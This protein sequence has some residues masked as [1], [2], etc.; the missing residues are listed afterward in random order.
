MTSQIPAQILQFR[1][2]DFDA[3]K[4]FSIDYTQHNAGYFVIVF[5]ADSV[6]GIRSNYNVNDQMVN[7]DINVGNLSALPSSTS[8]G[9]VSDG[10]Y[11]NQNQLLFDK[12]HE[13]SP[14]KILE[15]V[16]VHATDVQ[17]S[18]QAILIAASQPPPP[19]PTITVTPTTDETDKTIDGM[20]DRI[21]HDLD[22]LLNRM[23]EIPPAPP[24]P[25][26]T[27]PPPTLHST[28]RSV[29]EVILEE[30]AEDL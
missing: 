10:S 4:P 8:N 13:K 24:P 5:V 21:S 26:T 6:I 19:P 1:C 14:Q 2:S 20:L 11:V 22:Y 28:N 17:T 9:T 18:G 3:L 30:E 27:A 7:P 29:H 23:A 15:S 16:N 25:T 12:S